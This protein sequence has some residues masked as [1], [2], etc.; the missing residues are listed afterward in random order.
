MKILYVKTEHAGTIKTLFEVLKELLP[1]GN[2]EFIRP[3]KVINN[4]NSDSEQDSDVNSDSDAESGSDEEV[5]LAD[6]VVKNND[7]SDSD[8]DLESNTDSDEEESQL[9]KKNKEKKKKLDNASNET[10]KDVEKGGLKIMAVDTTKSVLLYVKLDADKFNKFICK[11][12]RL[13]LGVNFSFLHQLIKFVDRNDDLTFVVDDD[14]KDK[15]LIKYDRDGKDSESSLTLMDLDDMEP[16][17]PST[18]F[19]VVITMQATEF[20]RTCRELRTVGDCVQ[21]QCINKEIC[22]SC[23]GD[24][25]KS[26]TRYKESENGVSIYYAEQDDKNRP[27]V[28]QGV[29][30]LKNLALFGKCSSLCEEIQIYMKGTGPACLLAIKYTV[31]TLGKLFVCLSPIKSE[32]DSEEEVN[33]SDGDDDYLNYDKYYDDDINVK[34]K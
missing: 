1:E 12:K 26:T 30:E 32:D 8:S 21:I 27:K 17:I 13:V 2:L 20:Q 5:N 28:V 6:K 15:L 33:D 31:A 11:P 4:D 10:Q 14:E 34:Y 22:F 23:K 19:D 3:S 25:S 29:Y 7:D 18:H 16:V 24:Y 9:K